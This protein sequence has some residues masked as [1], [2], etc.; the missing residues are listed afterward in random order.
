MGNVSIRTQHNEAISTYM[1]LRLMNAADKNAATL[2]KLTAA[3]MILIILRCTPVE[4]SQ[5][6]QRGLQVP[7]FIKKS[8]PQCKSVVLLF[9]TIL[10]AGMLSSSSE[11][12]CLKSELR[13]LAY[14]IH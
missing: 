11:W 2:T 13:Y 8:S 1:V 3:A 6:S 7:L 5:L 4:D 12:E 14:I 10:M 9:G